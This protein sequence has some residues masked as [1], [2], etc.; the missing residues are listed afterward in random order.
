MELI[1]IFK[2]ILWIKSCGFTLKEYQNAIRKGRKLKELGADF[3]G[4]TFNFKTVYEGSKKEAVGYMNEYKYLNLKNKNIIEFK[5]DD[6]SIEK[7]IYLNEENIEGKNLREIPVFNE[8][9][10]GDPIEIN[11]EKQ[12]NFYLP[13]EWVDRNNENFILK[14]KGN[15]MIEKDINDGDGVAIGV[16][17]KN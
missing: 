6:S 15:S 11:D 14:I 16:I 7:E 1:E 9:A 5:I 17:K 12:E 8:I 4:R 3:K 10:A 2:E 13:K